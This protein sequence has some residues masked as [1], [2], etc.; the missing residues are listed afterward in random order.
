MNNVAFT[1]ASLRALTTLPVWLDPAS[2]NHGLL[3]VVGAKDAHVVKALAILA[4][5]G[6]KAIARPNK[7]PAH[8]RDLGGCD[9]RPYTDAAGREVARMVRSR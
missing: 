9:V 4:K 3:M 5:N 1:D 7:G 2:L 8:L 6:V